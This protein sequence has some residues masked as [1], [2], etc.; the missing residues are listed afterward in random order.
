MKLQVDFIAAQPISDQQSVVPFSRVHDFS[1]RYLMILCDFDLACTAFDSAAI[2]AEIAIITAPKADMD[3]S[4]QT[5]LAR[6][7]SADLRSTWDV[8]STQYTE[9]FEQFEQCV[10]SIVASERASPNGIRIIFP[11]PTRSSPTNMKGNTAQDQIPPHAQTT[12]NSWAQ[13]FPFLSLSSLLSLVVVGNMMS[14]RCRLSSIPGN[15]HDHKRVM[16]EEIKARALYLLSVFIPRRSYVPEYSVFVKVENRGFPDHESLSIPHSQVSIAWK[17]IRSHRS[18]S[19]TNTDTRPI[20][21]VNTWYE[22]NEKYPF[23]LFTS[24]NTCNIISNMLSRIEI[25][26]PL[27]RLRWR[28]RYIGKTEP[29]VDVEAV[30]RKIVLEY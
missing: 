20:I 22:S 15:R 2:L 19:D 13:S 10:E 1:N 18:S 26:F 17:F 5:Q 23:E 30:T 16:K 12:T 11:I 24:N 7:P 6:M 8:L 3:G 25:P 29:L 9:Q 27:D 21:D 28:K 14:K 4:V